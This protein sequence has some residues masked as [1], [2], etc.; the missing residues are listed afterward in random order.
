MKHGSITVSSRDE[1]LDCVVKTLGTT[2]KKVSIKG[3]ETCVLVNY[4]AVFERK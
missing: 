1:S 2:V 3:V 4:V